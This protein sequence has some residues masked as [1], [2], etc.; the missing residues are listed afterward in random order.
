M[1]G[2]DV[3]LNPKVLKKYWGREGVFKSIGLS[4]LLLKVRYEICQTHILGLSVMRK[5]IFK[6]SSF[7][8]PQGLVFLTS[9]KKLMQKTQ[10]ISMKK[11]RRIRKCNETR[12]EGKSSDWILY[13]WALQNYSVN[14]HLPKS[15]VCCLSSHQQFEPLNVSKKM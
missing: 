10:E 4:L 1:Q 11:E 14:S 7:F 9:C 12:P 13:F 3:S 2:T 8:F 15:I 5:W 6:K